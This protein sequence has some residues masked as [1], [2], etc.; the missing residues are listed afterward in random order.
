MTDTDYHD[1]G[2]DDW[3][4]A[5]EDGDGYYLECENGH[6]SLPPRR[7]RGAGPPP[8][9][10]HRS[11]GRPGAA[12]ATRG[13]SR[14]PGS[15]RRRPRWRPASRRS[16]RRGSLCRSFFH[17]QD[18]DGR[19]GDGATGVVRDAEVGVRHG[20]A[21]GVVTPQDAGH[22][23]DLGGPRRADGVALRLE[24]AGEVHRAVAV[25]G[26]LAAACRA[27]ALTGRVEVQRLQREHLR[28]GEAVVDLGDVDV[29]RVDTCIR[30]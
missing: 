3:L 14:T 7:R 30:V 2:Y 26:R 17:L 27:Y 16:P 8:G 23:D 15:S 18:V 11:R 5:I 19:A 10:S 22:L 29:R 9:R 21:V 28:D 20:V 1:E 24:A 13:R 6:G 4:D 12:A 25:A